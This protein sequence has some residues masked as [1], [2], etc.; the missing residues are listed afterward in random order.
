MI[1]TY[2]PDLGMEHDTS[3]PVELR[4]QIQAALDDTAR[5]FLEGEDLDWPR[6]LDELGA[7]GVVRLPATLL[8]VDP[9]SRYVEPDPD[10]M[11]TIVRAWHRAMAA[12][13]PAGHLEI[14]D[15]AGHLIHWD[16]PDLVLDRIRELVQ[17][18]R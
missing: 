17:R 7:A 16:R 9:E 2:E 10:R 3:L 15:G 18:L 12:R 13:Y 4:Q 8:F 6:T 11:A 14:V 5:S 1:D